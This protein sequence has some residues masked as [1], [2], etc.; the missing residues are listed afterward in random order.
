MKKQKSANKFTRIICALLAACMLCCVPAFPSEAAVVENG[1][2]VS[3]YQGAIDWQ[4]VAQSGVSFAFIKVGSTKSGIDPYFSYNMLAAQQ[5]GIKTGVYIYS[6]AKSVEEAAV[7]AQFVLSAI[8]DFQVS[9]PV[10]WDVED[11]VQKS[12]SPKRFLSWQIHSVP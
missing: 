11:N 4:A 2:D 7:E 9:Y 3:K 6:Y 12:L 1:I 5:A 10:V 8:Q